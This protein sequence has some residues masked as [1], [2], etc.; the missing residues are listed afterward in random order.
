MLLNRF[1]PRVE[2]DSYEDFK[3]NYKVQVPEDFNFGFDIVDAWADAEPEKKA[4][5]WCDDHDQERIFT[6]T[7]IKRLSNQAANFFKSIGVQK[8]SDS[9]LAAAYKERYCLSRQLRKGTYHR[10]CQRRFR[11]PPD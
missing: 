4:L 10:L 5:V 9:R 11:H 8:G 1:L 3:K 2:F 6:F 7:D